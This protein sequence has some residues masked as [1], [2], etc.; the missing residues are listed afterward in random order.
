MGTVSPSKYMS[1]KYLRG[2]ADTWYTGKNGKEY[3]IEE[4]NRLIWEKEGKLPHVLPEDIPESYRVEHLTDSHLSNEITVDTIFQDNILGELIM[5]Q[6]LR[7][8]VYS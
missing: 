7:N 2:L 1:L 3:E 8:E 4:V 6:R 5:E